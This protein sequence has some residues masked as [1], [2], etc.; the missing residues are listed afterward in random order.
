MNSITFLIWVE[1]SPGFLIASQSRVEKRMIGKVMDPRRRCLRKTILTTKIKSA[2]TQLPC[3]LSVS[4]GTGDNEL[5]LSDFIAWDDPEVYFDSAEDQP[6]DAKPKARKLQ[7]R[8]PRGHRDKEDPGN[9]TKN[10]NS[11]NHSESETDSYDAKLKEY[12][13]RIREKIKEEICRQEECRTR[14]RIKTKQ[15]EA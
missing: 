9:A 11:G 15:N 14:Y 10:N 1:S 6:Q 7:L 3:V 4:C 12:N 2:R 8:K 5:T 13:R